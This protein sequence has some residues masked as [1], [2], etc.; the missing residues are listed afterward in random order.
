MFSPSVSGQS[1]FTI[2]LF[3][4][5]ALRNASLTDLLFMGSFPINRLANLGFSF[6]LP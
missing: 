6:K 3:T 4:D 2:L 1:L 5:A